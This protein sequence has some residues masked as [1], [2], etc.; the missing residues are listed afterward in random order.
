MGAPIVTPLLTASRSHHRQIITFGW[1]LTIV[2]LVAASF[3]NNT[4]T[5]VATQGIMYGLGE[6]TLFFP[7]LSM[8]NEWFLHRRGLAYGILACSTGVSGL[9][10]PFIITGLLGRYG[11]RTTLRCLA[12][13][14]GILTAPLIPFLKNRLPMAR[15]SVPRSQSYRAHL[16]QFSFVQRPLFWLYAAANMFHGLAFFFPLLWLPTYAAS[17]GLAPSSGALLLALV[18]LAQVGGQLTFGWISDHGSIDLHTLMFV[19]PFISAVAA[20]L[21]WGLAHGTLAPLIVF[22]LIYG[23]FAAGYVVLWARMGMALVGGADNGSVGEALATY[24][25]FSFEK[26]VG[27]VLTGPVSAA[28]LKGGVGRGSFG[29]GYGGRF[30]G[31]IAFT[32]A[33]M[34]V[35]SGIAGIG[36]LRRF[37]VGWRTR[38]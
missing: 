31:I 20:F 2:S 27:N 4:P 29:G 28:L 10:F 11:F 12:V 6:L 23:F 3:A 37:L 30:G 21:L 13:G 25:V 16:A 9:I 34:V 35:S 24:S 18:S 36:G 5:L 7:I 22:S 14:I 26:G 33:C 17:V 15:V 1:A 32:G 19:S 8:I 38:R